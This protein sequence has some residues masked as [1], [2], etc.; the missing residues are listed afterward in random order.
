VGALERADKIVGDRIAVVL[1]GSRAGELPV[2]FDA[3]TGGF[4][5]RD[6]GGDNLGADTIARD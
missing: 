4:D 5:H 3:Q 2:P 1:E 6:S